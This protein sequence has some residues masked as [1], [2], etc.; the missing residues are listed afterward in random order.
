MTPCSA[1]A[2]SGRLGERSPS[3]YG[4]SV[5][6][7]APT[8][9]DSAS[10]SNSSKST[11]SIEAT[12]ASTGAP[13]SVHTSGSWRPVASAKPATR[14]VGVVRG[15]V[16]DGADHAGGAQ[17]DDAVP[18]PGARARAPR[19]RCRR[20][21]GRASHRSWSDPRL[22]RDR[23]PAE[24]RASRRASRARAGPVGSRRPRRRS[25][26]C[27]W[28]RCGRCG[29]SAT[30]DDPDSRH[31]SQ[32]CGRHTA[33]VASALRGLVVG[34]PAQLGR[35]DRRDGHHADPVRPF[36]GAT[37]FVD[38]APRPRRWIECRSTATHLAPR[39]PA[40]SRQTMPCCWAPT[41]TA[42]TSSRPP[43]AVDG[44]SRAAHHAAGSTSVPPGCGAEPE[45]T[46]SPVS[47]S[48]IDD[49]ARLGGRVDA[50]DESHADLLRVWNAPA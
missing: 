37:E 30:S 25:S 9:A 5:S 34:Q 4:T 21:P 14:P 46:V 36:A 40:E 45:R 35:G 17:R 48:Q 3:K 15:D 47:A 42:A 33:A 23:A 10:R 2:A 16:A 7:S 13:L 32:S 8:G 19:P 24:R 39:C 11:P 6:P 28:R 1:P 41:E 44:V 38:Q 49:L 50:R 29:V 20:R 26:R 43:A 22:R 27:R 31:V 12:A 18:R